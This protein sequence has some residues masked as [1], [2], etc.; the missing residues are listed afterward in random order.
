[1][2]R[3]TMITKGYDRASFLFDDLLKTGAFMSELMTHSED[4]IKFEV[5]EVSE[6]DNVQTIAC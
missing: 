2:F 6:D 3:L 4:E 1:M 5:S